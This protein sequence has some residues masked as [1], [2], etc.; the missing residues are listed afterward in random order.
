MPPGGTGK[1]REIRGATVA[2]RTALVARSPCGALPSAS[3]ECHS[4]VATGAALLYSHRGNDNRHGVF[5]IRILDPIHERHVHGRRVRVLAERLAEVIPPDAR[6]L[7]VGCG[8]GQ[9]DAMLGRLRPDL[10]IEGIDVLVRPS[11]R[12]MVTR[13]DGVRIPFADA[14]FDVVTFID[15]LHHT[16]DPEALLVEA[17]RVARKAI[18][19]KDH[20]LDGLLAGST[21][22]LMDRVGN[23]RHGVATPYNYWSE[24]RWRR[25]FGKLALEIDRWS[26]RI[27]LYPWPASLVFERR[28]HFIARLVPAD[29]LRAPVAGATT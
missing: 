4:V 7:D 19:L 10:R 18:V 2:R 6:V 22:R 15:V 28:L 11:A 16:D 25:T 1:G 27:G 13:F 3:Q 26:G 17:R 9:I 20:C 5:A 14:T 29:R 23:A 8:D 12:I 24:A 21:L